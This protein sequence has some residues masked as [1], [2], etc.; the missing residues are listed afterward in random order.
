MR[1]CARARSSSIG[2][3]SCGRTGQ[4]FSF[5]HL[6]IS[7]DI[8]TLSKSISGFGLPMSL[9][10]MK[11][12]LDVWSP[13]QHNGTFRGNNLAFVTAQAALVHYWTTREFQESAGISLSQLQQAIRRLWVTDQYADVRIL[14]QEVR[15]EDPASPVRLIIEV[16]EQPYVAYVEIRGLENVRLH[17]G[18]RE[19]T[20][21]VRERRAAHLLRPLPERE[22]FLVFIDT[23]YVSTQ[24]LFY[25]RERFLSLRLFP[26]TDAIID[27]A[28]GAL[29]AD[30]I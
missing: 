4:F 5:E 27:A 6:G 3:K 28:A 20:D 21:D 9:T 23:L 30:S 19:P 8:V 13:G 16:D 18:E 29:R 10:L 24:R 2:A 14:A 7:P 12:E 17:A 22:R 25:L 11:P 15:P 1:E 26:S